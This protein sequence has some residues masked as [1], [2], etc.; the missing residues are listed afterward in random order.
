M[1]RIIT[2]LAAILLFNVGYSN[3]QSLKERIESSGKVYVKKIDKL[4]ILVQTDV[5][6][7]TIP[8]WF[9]ANT[10]D[11]S[12]GDTISVGSQG[13]LYHFKNFE[14]EF[15]EKLNDLVIKILMEE[16]AGSVSFIPNEDDKGEN[17]FILKIFI[18]K[19]DSPDEVIVGKYSKED[20]DGSSVYYFAN[21]NRYSAT[22]F[23]VTGGQKEKKVLNISQRGSYNKVE[24]L[25]DTENADE[26]TA[27]INIEKLMIEGMNKDLVTMG[28]K[29]K[30]KV[31][32][33]LSK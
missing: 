31:A 2:V 1:K 22:L 11:S 8:N 14:S 21:R 9:S 23:E 12:P 30:K 19:I 16:V 3:A 7:S 10:V 32:K 17:Y 20:S 15:L 33:S 28:D 5:S 26:G 27:L 29:S 4:R 13:R 25:P 6:P 24:M 18:N